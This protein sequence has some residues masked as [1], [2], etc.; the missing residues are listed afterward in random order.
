MNTFIFQ[1]QYGR[2]EFFAAVS[3]GYLDIVNSCILQHTYRK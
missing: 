2:R 1:K 3:L